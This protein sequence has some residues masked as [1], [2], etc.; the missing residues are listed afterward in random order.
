MKKRV[1]RRASSQRACRIERSASLCFPTLSLHHPQRLGPRTN[2]APHRRGLNALSL[3]FL[4]IPP[5]LQ[6]RR[7]A[8]E[9]AAAEAAAKRHVKLQPLVPKAEQQPSTRSPSPSSSMGWVLFC[10]LVWVGTSCLSVLAPYVALSITHPH[11][12]EDDTKEHNPPINAH[13]PD[14]QHTQTA[15]ASA[16][17]PGWT[18]AAPPCCCTRRSAPGASPP[19]PPASQQLPKP[20]SSRPSTRTAA[21]RA[22]RPAAG[23]SS[24]RARCWGRGRGSATRARRLR[25]E[26]V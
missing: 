23:G 17:T 16:S 18:R 14:P 21:A 9:E 26:R 12:N 19:A 2:A 25:W 4:A 13:R 7:S 5:G 1:L 15:C 8:A 24:P 22:P 20:A 3:I 10:R 11:P 6:A